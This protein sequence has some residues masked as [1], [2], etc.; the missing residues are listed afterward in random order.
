MLSW[1]IPYLLIIFQQDI[2]HVGACEVQSTSSPQKKLRYDMKLC[3]HVSGQSNFLTMGLVF[4]N[5]NGVTLNCLIIPIGKLMNISCIKVMQAITINIY[6][7]VD[8]IK[9]AIQ[10]RL[11]ATFNQIPLKICQIQPR[12]IIEKQMNLT[13]FISD[14]FTEEPKAEPNACFSPEVIFIH[15]GIT[16]DVTLFLSLTTIYKSAMSRFYVYLNN[17]YLVEN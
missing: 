4:R 13:N 2:K 5:Q 12:S 7:D 9:V 6:Q 1:H 16:L 14:Y 11:G 3:L 15:I 8:E 17:S 10:I